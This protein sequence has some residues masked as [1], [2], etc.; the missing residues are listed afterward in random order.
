[1]SIASV[2]NELKRVRDHVSAAR[3]FAERADRDEY[4]RMD[5]LFPGGPASG[6]IKHCELMARGSDCRSRLMISANRT[7]K[8]VTGAYEAAVHLTGRYPDWWDGMRFD[9]PI[10]CWCAGDTAKTT[11]EF[12]Q[13]ALL[14]DGIEYGTG[15]VPRGSII[16]KPTTK[17]GVA[18]AVDTFEVRHKTGGIS[19]CVLKSYD[20]GEEAFMG[21]AVDFIWLDEEPPIRVVTECIIRTM[22]CNGRL[23]QT[24]TPVWGLTETVQHFMPSGSI[25]DPMP[26]GIHIVQATWEDAP[27][28]TP[29]MRAELESHIPPFQRDARM[30]GIPA[31]GSGAIYPIPESD[32]VVQ[33]FEIPD[34]WPRAYGM[35]VGWNRTAA[36][37]G[38]KD[39]DSGTVYLYSEY[40]RGEAE[41]SVHASA[42]RARGE[43]IPGV[44]D[45]A[46]RGRGQADGRQ[47][48]QDYMDLGLNIDLA[49][50]AVEAG[51][52]RGW[53][54]MSAGRLK[55]FATLQHWLGEYRV[56]RRDEKGRIVKERDHALDASR[57][58][59]MSGM[60]QA[61]AKP[62]ALE[63]REPKPYR[64]EMGWM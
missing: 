59:W 18:R 5:S 19:T 64:G 43:W 58:L 24:F 32:I 28:L 52:Y 45:P 21:K 13:A 50:N 12:V 48:L 35:D 37:W 56:Y 4:R 9:R 10:I 62:V 2:R 20:Q 36:I 27:H 22:T 11:R 44:I 1:M 26:S 39:P 54:L 30:R 8:T 60:D 47:L 57:Y 7:G 25:P 46:A 17:S 14:G 61:I 49:N 15:T 41:P 40:Y 42:I 6:Y 55:V 23:L 29:E 3:M 63:K 51:I 38:A 33:P 34:Y 16:G 31:L 53:E